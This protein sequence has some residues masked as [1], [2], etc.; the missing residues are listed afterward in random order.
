MKISLNVGMADRIVRAVAGVI[1]GALYLSGLVQGM[2][3]TVVLIAALAML[4]TAALGFC[5]LYT[6]L[7]ITTCP[8]KK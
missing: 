4:T 8:L 3:A 7:G 6:L 1:L 5:G 2:L